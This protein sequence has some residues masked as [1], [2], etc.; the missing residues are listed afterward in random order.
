MKRVNSRS[1]ELEGSSQLYQLLF[2]ATAFATALR[3]FQQG[4]KKNTYWINKWDINNAHFE[5]L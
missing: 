4:K 3:E 2:K 1:S 5:T